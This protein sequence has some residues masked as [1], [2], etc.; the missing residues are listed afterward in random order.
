MLGKG[1][2]SRS[3]L[4]TVLVASFACGGE[5]QIEQPT[6]LHGQMPIAYP[7]QL[8]DQDME[9][10][11]LLRV[12]VSD[13]GAVDSVEVERSSGYEAFDSAAVSGARWIR[14]NVLTGSYV[15]DQGVIDGEAARVQAYKNQLGCDVEILADFMV[16]HASPLGSFDPVVG[17]RDLA[18]RSGA[19]ALILTGDRTGSGV[20][21]E[22]LKTIR[23][24][25][26]GFPVWI[27]S[28]LSPESAQQLWPLCDGAIVGSS[29][30]AGGMAGQPVELERV[31]AM[32]AALSA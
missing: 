20:D 9:G 25:V 6:P 12:R 19:S 28:G 11:A 32:R 21:L 18:Q 17:A 23:M 7:I 14:I 27:G 3:A 22:F 26:Q 10:Q 1:L 31:R 29:L 2:A 16:K 24:A 8:W 30:Q 4:V 13:T 5:D 15:T